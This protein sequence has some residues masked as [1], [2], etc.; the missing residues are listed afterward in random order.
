ML[1]LSPSWSVSCLLRVL[2]TFGGHQNSKMWQIY[3]SKILSTCKNRDNYLWPNVVCNVLNEPKIGLESIDTNWNSGYNKHELVEEKD[4]L[5]EL[6]LKWYLSEQ[7]GPYLCPENEYQ[8]LE[9]SGPHQ[10]QYQYDF[11]LSKE[12][13]LVEIRISFLMIIISIK[14]K[15]TSCLSVPKVLFLISYFHTTEEKWKLIF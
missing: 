1:S 5:T 8:Y 11:I 6:Y 14:K 2:V 10:T 4:K 12:N 7:F 3:I 15:S 13:P 9:F